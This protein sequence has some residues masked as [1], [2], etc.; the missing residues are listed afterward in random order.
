ME[1]LREMWDARC[2]KGWTALVTNDFFFEDENLQLA[3][4]AGCTALLFGVESLDT[5]WLR[6]NKP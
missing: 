1:L 6:A 4:E 3:T 2:F 5:A